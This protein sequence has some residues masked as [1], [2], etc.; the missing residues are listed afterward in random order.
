MARIKLLKG[1]VLFLP[2]LFIGCINNEAK[3][4]METVQGGFARMN[5]ETGEICLFGSVDGKPF[6]KVTCAK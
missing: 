4:Q 6:N 3:F 1:L 5:R 2:L